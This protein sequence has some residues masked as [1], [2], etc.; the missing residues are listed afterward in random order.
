MRKNHSP[1]V[2]LLV[3]A[4][5]FS[6]AGAE[7]APAAKL[8]ARNEIPAQTFETTYEDGRIQGDYFVT[9]FHIADNAMATTFM[10]I[11]LRKR[12]EEELRRHHDQ[13]EELVENRTVA[14]SAAN[15]RGS[16]P[17]AAGTSF[18]TNSRPRRAGFFGL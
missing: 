17:D 16:F 5:L 18:G 15:P 6:C 11:T 2:A 7:S 14:L 10:D 12:M 9:V 4:M 13:L 1:F 8:P 3:G